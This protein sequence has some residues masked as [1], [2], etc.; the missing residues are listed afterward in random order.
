MAEPDLPLRSGC[1]LLVAKFPAPLAP[2]SSLQGSLL[3]A[4][5]NFWPCS[6]LLLGLQLCLRRLGEMRDKRLNLKAEISGENA[7][8][9]VVRAAAG[10]S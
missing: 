8:L 6:L 2:P 1:L 9:R 7:V 5:T 10:T 4:W 3:S